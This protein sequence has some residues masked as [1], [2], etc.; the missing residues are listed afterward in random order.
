MNKI[1]LIDPEYENFFNNELF[2]PL[3]KFNR[4]N[5]LDP[6]I[7]LKSY[8]ES[9]GYSIF[10]ADQFFKFDNQIINDSQFYY[11]SIGGSLYKKLIDLKICNI[12]FCNYII[13]EPPIVNNRP[14]LNLDKLLEVFDH[15][16]VHNPDQYNYSNKFK[17]LYWPQPDFTAVYCNDNRIMNNRVALINSKHSPI[18]HKLYNFKFYG[19]LELYS[20]RLRCFLDNELIDLYGSKWDDILNIHSLWFLYLINYFKIKK[21]Y[22][23]KVFNKSD[24][25][26]L[27]NFVLCIENQSINGYITEKIFDSFFSGS[28]PIYLGAPDVSKYIPS[29]LYI[30]IRKFDSIHSAIQHC[31]LM[32]DYEIIN[33]RNRIKDYLQSKHFDKYKFSLN[34]IFTL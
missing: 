26:N 19:D 22:G 20:Y 31:M 7:R 27:Y 24:V 13:F 17:K 4:D 30:D 21:R 10:T 2:N 33:Y 8:I 18:I 34:R 29:D 32:P 23:G 6:Y 28:I 12:S 15:I 25:Y 16:Y 3:S 11:T 9:L 1:F 5:T 14:Y